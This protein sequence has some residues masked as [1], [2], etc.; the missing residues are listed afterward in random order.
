MRAPNFFQAK[1]NNN[2]NKSTSHLYL[3][4]V[5][6][7]FI[8]KFGIEMDAFRASLHKTVTEVIGKTNYSRQYPNKKSSFY[9][10]VCGS[11][12]VSSFMWL[13][14][15]LVFVAGECGIIY[16]VVGDGSTT[17]ESLKEVSL[18]V[19]EILF[20][21]LTFTATEHLVLQRMEHNNVVRLFEE[22]ISAITTTLNLYLSRVTHDVGLVFARKSIPVKSTMP[23]FVTRVRRQWLLARSLPYAIVGFLRE[24]YVP[25]G[26]CS[27]CAPKMKQSP[28]YYNRQT[29]IGLVSSDEQLSKLLMS[30]NVSQE[31]ICE[32]IEY[33]NL[34]N[35]SATEEL[36]CCT[37]QTQP[38]LHSTQWNTQTQR[39][40]IT[41]YKFVGSTHIVEGIMYVTLWMWV[42]V[43]PIA[44]WHMTG[45]YILL[46]FLVIV[47]PLLAIIKGGDLLDESFFYYNDKAHI[48]YNAESRAWRTIEVIDGIMKF[49]INTLSPDLQIKFTNSANGEC[50]G[51]RDSVVAIQN[52]PNTL[53]TATSSSIPR[54][55]IFQPKP[56]DSGDTNIAD[57]DIG[58]F[59]DDSD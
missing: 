58:V 18:Y 53:P 48:S 10:W 57:S 52:V 33:L 38:Y 20:F 56:I 51:D 37:R 12:F 11:S 24:R 39:S 47:W 13:L 19:A 2:S 6:A 1:N 36:T 46:I 22:N 40:N 30:E 35:Y 42:F 16:A 59:S 54:V 41:T 44:L 28:Y 21:I 3:H 34:E 55:V 45:W 29:L 7:Y 4:R 5:C 43:V 32:K 15:V 9:L 14:A 25:S 8:G 31:M 27:C 17:S 50:H 23:E 49:W 26:C